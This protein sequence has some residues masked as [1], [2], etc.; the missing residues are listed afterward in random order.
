MPAISI[1]IEQGNYDAVLSV[2]ESTGKSRSGVINWLIKLGNA[3][4]QELQAQ[5]DERLANRYRSRIEDSLVGE[6]TQ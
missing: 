5:E 1:S 3:R 6:V 4:R 2:C